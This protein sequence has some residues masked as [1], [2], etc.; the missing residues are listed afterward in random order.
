MIEEFRASERVA[1]RSFNDLLR[2]QR[3]NAIDE[4]GLA[5]AIDHSV[6]PRWRALRTRVVMAT[7]ANSDDELLLVLR[8][9]LAK[10]QH[11]WEAYS[12]A[13]RSPTDDA[14]KPHYAIYHSLEAAAVD[15]ARALG[16]AFRKL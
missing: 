1:L 11:A 7:G 13:L 3:D 5:D 8:S 4:I 10:R 16:A 9:Y 6:L 12:A 14:A 2:R 15:D